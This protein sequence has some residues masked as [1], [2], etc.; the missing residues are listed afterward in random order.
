M[1]DDK[2]SIKNKIRALMAKTTEAGCSEAEAL[3][4]AHKVQELLN[5]YELSISDMKLKSEST[6]VTGAYDVR[7]KSRP[8]VD[9]CIA[10]IS[11]FTDTKC[12]RQTE[13][14]GLITYK[15]FGLESDVMIAEYV[16]KVVDWALIY[17]GEDYKSS[18]VYGNA[19]SSQRSK[20]L[21]DFRLAMAQRIAAKLRQM[22]D[23][24]NKANQSTGRDLVVLKSAIV[25]EEWAK[26]GIRLN[27]A[28]KSK[29]HKFSNADAYHAGAKAG[30]AFQLNAGVRGTNPQGSIE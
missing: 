9:W 22:K 30:D 19:T 10:A 15:Y 4:A 18:P 14:N 3:L 11:Y 24:Q 16:T 8:P 26:E 6:C 12:W 5:K 25:T 17:G 21:L 1:M 7:V 29:G 20:I 2:E 28:K 13:P 27:K 23:E